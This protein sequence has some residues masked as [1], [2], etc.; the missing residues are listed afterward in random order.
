[1]YEALVVG[2]CS[3]GGR[4]PHTRKVRVY[5]PPATLSDAE[6]PVD[7]ALPAVV[8]I[9]ALDVLEVT[10]SGPIERPEDHRPE[11]AGHCPHAASR[12]LI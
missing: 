6:S 12:P 10:V 4:K 3:R 1:M 11:E 2:L 9:T 5:A 7:V 8:G